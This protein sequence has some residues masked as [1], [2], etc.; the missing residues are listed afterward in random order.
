MLTRKTRRLWGLTLCL[1]LVTVPLTQPALA[2]RTARYMAHAAPACAPTVRDVMPLHDRLDSLLILGDGETVVA[3][4]GEALAGVRFLPHDALLVLSPRRHRRIVLPLPSYIT[5]PGL[6]VAGTPTAVYAVV[7]SAMLRLDLA[8]GRLVLVGRLDMQAIG[9][10]AAVAALNGRLYVVGQPRTAWAAAAE[11]FALSPRQ[12]PHLLWRASLGLTHAG[13]WLA[14]AGHGRLDIYLPNAHDMGGSIALLDPRDGALHGAYTVSSPPIAVDPA[15]NRLYLGAGGAVRAL[16]LDRGRP[17]AALPSGGPLALDP[18][19]GIV[20][21]ATSDGIT[22]ATAR[23]L[24]PLA[25]L[26]LHGVTALA[27]APD[28]RALLAGTTSGLARIDLG[29]CYA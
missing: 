8:A 13:I 1:A 26:A 14:P 3:L 18:A 15:H 23:A 16:T 11:A 21:V 2:L 24:R 20:A 10:P 27:A 28:G 19:R 22:L 6:V 4:A 7:D 12:A 29:T 25:H 5:P 17:V 9:W